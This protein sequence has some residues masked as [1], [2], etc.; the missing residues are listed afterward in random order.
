MSQQNP[1]EPSQE[2]APDM[3]D[4]DLNKLKEALN[5]LQGKQN[6]AETIANDPIQFVHRYHTWQDQEIAAIFASSLSFGKVTLFVPIIRNWLNI[7]DQ[8]GGPRKFVENFSKT[9]IPLLN[10]LLYRW[11]KEPDFSLLVFTLQRT[12]K[13]HGSCKS[14]I[15]S[16]YIPEDADI[17]P[18]LARFIETLQKYAVQESIQ[19]GLHAPNFDALP[20]GFKRFLSSPNKGSA[21]KRWQ[22]LL[23][24]MVRQSAPDIGIWDLP[25]AKLCI[26]LDIHVHGIA[27]ML[28]ILNSS[29]AN[30]KAA[31]RISNVLRQ[32]SPTDPIQYD[33]AMAHLGISGGCQKRYVR[34]ICLSCPLQDLCIHTKGKH[35]YQNLGDAS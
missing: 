6:I 7:C 33:F 2:N 3:D 24:W 9:D 22:M 18:T 1:T 27:R 12:L 19:V 28:G 5:T 26:P 31:Q 21:C 8:W 25:P 29:T 35:P 13:A 34:E 4:I 11:N 16:L 32:I 10:G 15:E 23:R 20:D 14:L 17:N 30:L